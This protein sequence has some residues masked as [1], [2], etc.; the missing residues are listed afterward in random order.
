ILN[1]LIDPNLI[2][3]MLSVGLLGIVVELWHPGLIFPGTI[4]A[5]SLVIA[6]YGLAVLPVTWAGILLLLLAFGFWGA[7]PFVMSH[8]ALAL[9]GGV[10]FVLGTLFLFKPA[11]PQVSLPLSIGIA[12]AVTAFIAFVVAKVIS[13]RRRAPAVGTNNM[14]G[15][16][17][18]V[19]AAGVVS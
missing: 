8:G 4:G 15:L 14:I 17:G 5:L 9:A 13:L 18:T 7:E 12:V 2:A 10:F 11:G 19:R 6:L 16:T 1:T 3:L